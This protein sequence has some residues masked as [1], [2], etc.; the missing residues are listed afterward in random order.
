[1]NVLPFCVAPVAH[2]QQATA[3]HF[4]LSPLTLLKHNNKQRPSGARH[5]AMFL[6][7]TMTDKSYPVIGRHFD[8]DHTTIMSAV[9]KV[10]GSPKLL[11]AA[12][13]IRARIEG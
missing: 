11:R 1:M 10:G 5:V 12:K 4:R 13:K 8:R 3:R 9:R 7:R 6:A 2:I